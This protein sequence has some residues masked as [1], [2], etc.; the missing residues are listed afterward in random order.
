MTILKYLQ[1][2]L[3]SFL[4]KQNM[5][6]LFVFTLKIVCIKDEYI[7]VFFCQRT[8]FDRGFQ[9]V[10]D[11]FEQLIPLLENKRINLIDPLV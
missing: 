10:S 7:P 3:D 2:L 8:L 5:E 9:S 11:I 6:A 1:A 4:F